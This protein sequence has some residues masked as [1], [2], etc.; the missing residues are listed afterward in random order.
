MAMGA[1][2]LRIEGRS[3]EDSE[4]ICCSALYQP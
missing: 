2:G 1:S 3:D 4:T